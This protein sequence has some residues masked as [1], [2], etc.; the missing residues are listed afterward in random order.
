MAENEEDLL[1]H[2]TFVEI[3]PNECLLTAPLKIT[4]EFDAKEEI[5]KF[6]AVFWD[7]SFIADY[8]NKRKTVRLG[9]TEPTHMNAG[10]NSLV[11]AIDE[12]DVQGLSRHVLANVGLLSLDLRDADAPPDCD[13]LVHIGMVTH[14]AVVGDDLVRNIFNP[15]E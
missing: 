10:A 9:G 11:F 12:V 2:P 13:P 3:D 6:N 5:D 15:L 14:V 7:I 4:I 1:I 8:A